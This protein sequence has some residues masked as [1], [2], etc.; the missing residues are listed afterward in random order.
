MPSTRWEA[1]EAST[2]PYE[3]G[4]SDNESMTWQDYIQNYLGWLVA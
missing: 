1:L 4:L 3:D 2:S